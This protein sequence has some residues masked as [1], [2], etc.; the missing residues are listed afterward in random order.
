MGGW[1]TS[2][3]LR[4]LEGTQE[5]LVPGLLSFCVMLQQS[6]DGGWGYLFCLSLSLLGDLSIRSLCPW[7]HLAWLE[8]GAGGYTTLESACFPSDCTPLPPW[9]LASAPLPQS[10]LRL[11]QGDA[12][13][14][15]SRNYLSEPLETRILLTP[16]FTPPPPPVR[17]V[18]AKFKAVYMWTLNKCSLV[19]RSRLYALTFTTLPFTLYT[20]TTVC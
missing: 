11:L 4:F 1:G 9:C 8:P 19:M 17:S 18:T 6:E 5:P 20:L 12:T 2:F 16:C 7:C 3:H 10:L 15:S 14:G 13:G